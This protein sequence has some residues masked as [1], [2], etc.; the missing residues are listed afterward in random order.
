METGV[1]THP[2]AF[3]KARDLRPWTGYWRDPAT[4]RA[5]DAGVDAW[6][7][8]LRLPAFAYLYRL[9]WLAET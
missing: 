2:L 9:G 8:V 6:G 3:L 5:E 4:G 1:V 7:G